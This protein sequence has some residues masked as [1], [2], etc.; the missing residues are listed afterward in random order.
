MKKNLILKY[1][2]ACVACSKVKIWAG[3][4]NVLKVWITVVIFYIPV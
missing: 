2:N 3:K 4:T 1:F